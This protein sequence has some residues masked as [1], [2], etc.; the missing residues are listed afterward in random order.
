MLSTSGVLWFP[1][2]RKW[3][4]RFSRN[5]TVQFLHFPKMLHFNSPKMS[6]SIPRKKK[7][8]WYLENCKLNIPKRPIS[9]SRKFKYCKNDIFQSPRMT[10]FNLPKIEHFNLPKMTHFNLPKMTH[11]TLPKMTHFN[12]P[13]IAHFNQLRTTHFN[14]PKTEVLQFPQNDLFQSPE[15]DT[16]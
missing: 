13:K 6:F 3:R 7:T 8:F 5:W 9:I 10:Q 15:N 1:C 11:F 2:R 12:L 16:F 14:L 4:I